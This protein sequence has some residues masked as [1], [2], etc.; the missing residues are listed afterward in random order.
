MKC[1]T[2]KKLSGA[3][4]DMEPGRNENVLHCRAEHCKTTVEQWDAGYQPFT[5][6][7]DAGT[8]AGAAAEAGWHR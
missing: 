6:V 1:P 5:P 3:L 2:C 7:R 4:V 8:L